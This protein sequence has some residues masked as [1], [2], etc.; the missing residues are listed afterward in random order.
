MEYRMLI[1]NGLVILPDGSFRL[2]IRTH[3]EKI[4]NLAENLTPEPE[5]CVIDASG[6][7]VLP[8]FIDSSLHVC[9]RIIDLSDHSL[10][11]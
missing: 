6:R 5:E 9:K 11:T 10:S 1:C 3:D 2:D 7:L 8:G 4:V